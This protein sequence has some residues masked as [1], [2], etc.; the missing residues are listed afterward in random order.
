MFSWLYFFDIIHVLT[1]RQLFSPGNNDDRH[2]Y[3]LSLFL[4]S[5]I[6]L[7]LSDAND[8]LMNQPA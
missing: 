1:E 8:K 2:R 4:W 7:T 6:W 5:R 3:H